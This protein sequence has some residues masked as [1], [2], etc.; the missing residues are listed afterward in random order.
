MS[1]KGGASLDFFASFFLSRQFNEAALI[2][3]LLTIKNLWEQYGKI[4]KLEN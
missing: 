1:T 2:Q 4:K 3:N